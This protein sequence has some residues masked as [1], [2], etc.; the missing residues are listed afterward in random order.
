MKNEILAGL[1]N[2][3]D[4]GQ[5]LEQAIHSFINAGYN[6]QEVRE[7]ARTLSSGASEIIYS[8]VEDEERNYSAEQ[9]QTRE[10][11]K[12]PNSGRERKG[13]KILLIGII[14]IVLLVFLGALGYL[15]FNLTRG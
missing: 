8:D 11:I 13:R 7:V 12:N 2:A 14:I 4:R 10:I 6:P 9:E 3:L 5:S 1:K 15:I